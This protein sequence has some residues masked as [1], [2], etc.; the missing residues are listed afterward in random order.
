MVQKCPKCRLVN[1]PDARRCDCGYDFAAKAMRASYLKTRDRAE[2]LDRPL[3]TVESLVCIFLPAIG[4]LWGFLLLVSRRSPAGRM[5]G[6]SAAFFVL[7][8]VV[9]FVV[10]ALIGATGR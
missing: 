7:W 4:L 9:R 2:L 8:T 10:S 3:T 5:L 1:P 6:L